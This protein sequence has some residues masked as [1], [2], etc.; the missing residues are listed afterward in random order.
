V[1]IAAASIAPAPAREAPAEADALAALSVQSGPQFGAVLEQ[2]LAAPAS[3]PAEAEA[4][5]GAGED[6]D[7]EP[8]HPAGQPPQAAAWRP[9]LPASAL[10]DAGKGDAPPAE[11]RLAP[12]PGAP[13]A[14]LA[15]DTAGNGGDRGT[16][17]RPADFACT[18]PE[19]DPNPQPAR[20][21]RSAQPESLRAPERVDMSRADAL[22][23]AGENMLPAPTAAS[24]AAELQPA[25]G[26]ALRN[27]ADDMPIAGQAARLIDVAPPLRS[28]AWGE[29]FASQ[30]AL[31]AANGTQT[32]QIR[33]SP[34]ELGPITM[35]IEIDDGRA[36]I[37]FAA[38]SE[39]TRA[40]IQQAL[41]L[42]REQLAAIN[43]RLDDAFVGAGFAERDADPRGGRLAHGAQ[44]PGT[45]HEIAAGLAPLRPSADRIIDVYA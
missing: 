26:A 43:V 39:E 21:V 40:A 41:P 8:D 34:A 9:D 27:L 7:A 29:S 4:R 24:A 1:T 45:A 22:R 37:A 28:G 32:A 35:S 10:A 13:R 23:A 16:P 17:P 11:L 3:A 18:E 15:P 2:A 25:P 36:R 33:V 12:F 31:G 38:S 30:I 42:L 14:G 20:A 44:D 19:S 6:T 5:P